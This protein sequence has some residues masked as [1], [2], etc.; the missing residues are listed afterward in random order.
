MKRKPFV[1]LFI[2][3]AGCLVFFSGCAKKNYE[4]FLGTGTY[5]GEYWPTNAWRTCA[6]EEVG[7]DS[8]R[9]YEVY[10]YAANP[11]INTRGIIIIR[12]G[13]IV[14]EAYF[15]GYSSNTRFPSYSIAKSFLSSLFGIAINQNLV[16]SVDEKVS[17]YLVEWTNPAVEEEK[18]R[19]TIRHLLTMSSGLEWNEDDYYNDQSQNDVFIM[20]ETGGFLQ[21]VL[22]KPSINEPGTQWYYSSGDSMLLSGILERAVNMTA[23]EF[24]QEHLLR[25]IGAVGITW[26]S[27][28]AGHT[29]G[30]W[31]VSAAV[32][33]YAK[34]GYLYLRNGEWAGQQIVPR[35]WV[36]DSTRPARDDVTWYGYQWWLASVLQGFQGSIVPP[37]TFL[38]WGIYT[39][40]IFVI[41]EEDIVIV[42]VGNDANPYNDEWREVE[43][44]TLVLQSLHE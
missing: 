12:Y 33:E 34:F 38:A 17:K 10:E 8:D 42:R 40:Q 22:A 31:G 39:Q 3:I 9:L 37:G 41:P 36:E 32:R 26:D 43:F 6:P 24:A 13:Y 35:Q 21:Y 1:L 11:N 29:I 18:Q 44:L 23:Y 20:A 5:T 27:D 4:S 16:E 2:L 30:G 14:G 15:Q 25:P 28:P 19:M 7:M